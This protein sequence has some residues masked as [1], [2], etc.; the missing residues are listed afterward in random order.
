MNELDAQLLPKAGAKAAAWTIR[1]AIDRMS[2]RKALTTTSTQ[3]V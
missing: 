2:I 1:D 3:Y